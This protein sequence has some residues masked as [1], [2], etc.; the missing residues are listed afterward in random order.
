MQVFVLTEVACCAVFMAYEK[1]LESSPAVRLE[2]KDRYQNALGGHTQSSF[3]LSHHVERCIEFTDHGF[4][5]ML[6]ARI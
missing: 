4:N 3:G 5:I 2:D 6:K 1:K